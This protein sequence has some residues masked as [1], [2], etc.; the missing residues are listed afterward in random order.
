MLNSLDRVR[1]CEAARIL[2]MNISV[3][4][5]INYKLSKSGNMFLIILFSV[6]NK[7]KTKEYLSS[8]VA[9]QELEKTVPRFSNTISFRSQ[10][11]SDLRS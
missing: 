2:Y 4:C 7:R 11:S 9:N 5:V 10:K 8:T 1:N 6:R 3:L